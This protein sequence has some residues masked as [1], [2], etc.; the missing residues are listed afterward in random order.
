MLEIDLDYGAVKCPHCGDI[1]THID[2]VVVSNANH[3]QVA[4]VAVGE[5][6]ASHI[7][8]TT[9]KALGDY[10]GRRHTIRIDIDCENCQTRSSLSL[11]QHKG[12]TFGAI[13]YSP[14]PAFEG[15]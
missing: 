5:D 1:W 9:R 3:D 2:T 10:S 7:D 15:I 6:S 14:S 11:H 13:T 12:N 8:I 4:V